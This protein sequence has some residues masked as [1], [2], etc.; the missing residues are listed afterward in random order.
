VG[1]SKRIAMADLRALFE[2]LGYGNVQTL[3]NSG[4]VVFTGSEVNADGGSDAAATIEGAIARQ[5]GVSAR[6]TVVAGAELA[7]IVAENP[8]LDAMTDPSRLLV[9]VVRDPADLSRLEPLVRQDWAPESLALGAR[10]AYLWCPDGISA[11]QLA[12]AVERAMGQRAT[13]RNWATVLKL[14]ARAGGVGSTD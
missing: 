9:S 7:T 12:F 6:V 3:L 4:N 11:G 14:H 5:L 8:L 10:A 13:A 1:R 2:G